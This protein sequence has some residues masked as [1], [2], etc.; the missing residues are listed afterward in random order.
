[1]KNSIGVAGIVVC[2][3][4]GVAA[5]YIAI[6][7]SRKVD[8][9]EPRA[10]KYDELCESVRSALHTDITLLHDTDNPPWLTPQQVDDDRR[11]L[12]RRVGSTSGGDDSYAM[13]GRCMPH[14]FPMDAWRACHDDA[15]LRATL[16]QAMD[17]IP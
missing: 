13:L 14:P 15:C 9:L 4:V 12:Y 16:K 8:R 3:I 17:S 10:K 6:T 5:T 1:M 2:A 7:L 11:T